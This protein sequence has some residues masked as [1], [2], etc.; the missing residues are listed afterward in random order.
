MRFATGLFPAAA[1][2]VLASSP[3]RAEIADKLDQIAPEIE[4]A[5]WAAGQPA[6][7]SKLRGRVVVLH[8]SDP[9]RVT[10]QAALPAL[11][12]VAEAWKDRPVTVVEVVVSPMQASA[13][14]YAAKSL[15]PWSVGWDGKG[16][17]AARFA[18][19]SVP[20]TYLLGPEGR[21]VWH[22]HVGALTK[23]LVQAQVDRVPFFA[24]GRDV[25]AARGVARAA[26]EQRFG[27]ALAEAAKVEADKYATDADRA[28][29]ALAR[30]DVARTWELQK[31][32]LD[33]LCRDLDWG[34]AWRR[35]QRMKETFAGTDKEPAIDDVIA[36]LEAREI[37]PYVRAGQ[38]LLDRIVEDAAKAKTR[39][40]LSDLV[41]RCVLFEE[42]YGSTKPGERCA[43]LRESLQKRLADLEAK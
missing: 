35:A 26:A 34:Y 33:N 25:K 24:P 22:A 12:K 1:I 14:T 2:V 18:G 21:I 16:T 8:F 17:S 5:A 29:C 13:T 19:T 40:D 20:R 4:C 36:K 6:Q 10:S 42:K 38:D 27:A 31:K 37:V 28:M 11:R 39:K 30:A 9:D 41:E 3:A 43:S 7:L 15:P 23:D 32:V